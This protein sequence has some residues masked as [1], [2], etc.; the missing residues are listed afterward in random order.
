[1]PYDEYGFNKETGSLNI[2]AIPR[3]ADWLRTLHWTLPT[4]VT[5]F[6][7]QIGGPEEVH[8]FLQLPAAEAMPQLLRDELVMHGHVT[9]EQIDALP[10]P[11]AN[12]TVGE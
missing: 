9:L 7:L 6:L 5:E 10:A 2:D 12:D 3:N 11:P 4:D 8:R 1:M